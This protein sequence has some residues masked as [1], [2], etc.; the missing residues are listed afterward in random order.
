MPICVIPSLQGFI[1]LPQLKN[2]GSVYSINKANRLFVGIGIYVGQHF[3]G[4][5]NNK[6]LSKVVL[7]I[8]LK[9]ICI[10]PM[11]NLSLCALQLRIHRKLQMRFNKIQN[12]LYLA[13]T[14]T[15]SFQ[16]KDGTS[17]AL[18]C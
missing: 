11:T 3:F 9:T 15:A 8:H 1:S 14:I 2:D 17:I 4:C 16:S 7:F 5:N 6:N 13:K 12:P 10:M 18:W